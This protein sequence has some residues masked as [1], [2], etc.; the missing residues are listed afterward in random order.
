MKITRSVVGPRLSL[1]VAAK[2]ERR[3][4][5]HKL[6]EHS[7]TDVTKGNGVRSVDGWTGTLAVSGRLD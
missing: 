2:T 1:I 6:Q 4:V 3:E 7:K 5:V